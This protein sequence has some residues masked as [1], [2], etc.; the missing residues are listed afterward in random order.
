MKAKL[1]SACVSFLSLCFCI[2]TEAQYLPVVFNNTYENITHI[3]Q[4]VPVAGG[5][6]VAVGRKD[7]NA[8]CIWLDREGNVVFSKEFAAHEFGVITKI[9]PV[10]DDKVL[11]VGNATVDYG[12]NTAQAAGKAIILS[13]DGGVD[14]EYEI[15]D[16]YTTVTGGQVLSNSDCIFWGKKQIVGLESE[17]VGYFCRFNSKEKMIYE[18]TAEKGT[19]CQW[20]KESESTSH[21]TAIFNGNGN[22]GA[23]V[24]RVDKNGVAQHITHLADDSFIIDQC[25]FAEGYVYLSGV[26]NTYGGAVVKIRPEG[27]IVFVK[28]IVEANRANSMLNNLLVT[29]KGELLVGGTSGEQTIFHILRSD[30]TSLSKLLFAGD[31]TALAVNPKSGNVVLALYN[32]NQQQGSLIK[33]TNDGK[34]LFE[35]T[36]ISRYSIIKVD[37]NDDILLASTEQDRISMFSSFGELLFDRFVDE[38]RLVDYKGICIANSGEVILTNGQDNITKMAHGLYIDDVTI[39]KP[40]NGIA[41]AI[42]T[43]TLSGY[44]YSEEGA[45]M[46]V[47]VNYQTQENTAAN[48]YNFKNVEGELSFIPKIHAGNQYLTREVIEVPVIANEFLEGKKEFAVQ[49]SAVDNSYI[50]KKEGIGT[51]DDQQGIVKLINTVDGIEGLRDIQ[52][53]L[54]LFKS[55]GVKLTNKTGADIVIDGKYGEGSADELDYDVTKRPRLKIANNAHSGTLSVPTIED[56]RYEIAKT[57]Y[58]NFE[59]VHAMSDTR[60]ALPSSA[61]ICE[62]KILDQEAYVSIASLGKQSQS[63]TNVS[64]FAKITLHRAKD[65]AVQTNN[66]GSDILVEIGIDPSST[67]QRG[68]DFAFVN[69][70]DLKIIGDGK[71]INI[72]LNGIVIYNPD[73]NQNKELKINLKKVKQVPGAG[74]IA[75]DTKDK[76]CQLLIVQKVADEQN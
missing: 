59:E 5:D 51:I 9:I 47:T 4:A 40:I 50:I 32:N 29:Q 33:L 60:I 54:G 15:G 8:V 23:S 55:N 26:G 25:I 71:H 37:A 42:F 69:A 34:K 68:F 2:N 45:P 64:G 52:Y 72:N 43:V 21:V 70:H 46:P 38:N 1:F 14:A 19:L 58:I 27:D 73:S 13:A 62:G 75:I 56:T 20:V 30:G 76:Q 53:E 3:S 39:T 35:K 18:F 57:L 17:S 65:G 63:N 10:K 31:L 12:K 49:L 16:E 11:I 66:S 61:L 6:V 67:A 36:L 24:V 48:Q 41:T 7:D 74:K 28:K 22:E 44:S